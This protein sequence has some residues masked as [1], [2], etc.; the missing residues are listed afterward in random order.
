MLVTCNQCKVPKE[1]SKFHKDNHNKNGYKKRC[2]KCIGDYLKAYA[3]IHKKPAGY[4]YKQLKARR[5]R[6]KKTYNIGAGTLGRYGLKL[7][8]AIYNRDNWQCRFCS[9]KADLTIDHIDRKGRNYENRGLK[10]NNDINNLR[11]LC[12]PCH[13]RISGQCGKKELRNIPYETV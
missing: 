1:L 11:I 10:P 2:R 8:L 6:I 3:K 12:R 7:T 9:A 5:A 4:W 13:G